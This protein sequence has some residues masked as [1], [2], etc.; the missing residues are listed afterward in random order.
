MWGRTVTSSVSEGSRRC[1]DCFVGLRHDWIKHPFSQRVISTACEESWHSGQ[2]DQR[3]DSSL[4]LLVSLSQHVE[5]F[6]G[7]EVKEESISGGG[8]DTQMGKG[9][10]P[11]RQAVDPR[12]G[13][14]GHESLTQLEVVDVHLS[15]CSS[16]SNVVHNG[17]V[18]NG[19]DLVVR[20]NLVGGENNFACSNI[21]QQ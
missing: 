18:N 12:A 21:H 6:L 17:S 20:S 8:S 11:E 14:K 2:E 15:G 16:H 3:C 7:I 1:N 9:V 13:V 5:T 10:R 4:T 19:G